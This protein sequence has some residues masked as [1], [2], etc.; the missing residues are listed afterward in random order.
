MVDGGDQTDNDYDGDQTVDENN[1]IDKIETLNLGRW[2]PSIPPTNINHH[3]DLK[4][5]PDFTYDYDEI[6]D[7]ID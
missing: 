3:I 5:P 6:S 4:V 1:N 7:M 2:L